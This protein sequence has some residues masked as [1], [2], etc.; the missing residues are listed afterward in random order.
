MNVWSR[1]AYV[2]DGRTLALVAL[3]VRNTGDEP[4][5]LDTGA[6]RLDAYRSSGAQRPPAR[7]VRTSQPGAS[8]WVPPDETGTIQLVYAIPATVRPDDIGS[9]RLR[10]YGP[11]CAYHMH[12]RVPVGR[13]VIRDR[14]TVH[15]VQ[16]E[17]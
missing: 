3:E 9:M 15:T 17:R 2:E 12:Y 11:P 5:L 8:L 10:W 7:L 4:V 14:G 16:R 13:T 6:L 1:G